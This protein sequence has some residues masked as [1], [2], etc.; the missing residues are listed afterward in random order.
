MSDTNQDAT[1]SLA[2]LRTA[3]FSNSTS[4]RITS[5]GGNQHAL[6]A[7]LSREA[8]DRWLNV[9]RKSMMNQLQ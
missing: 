5:T 9:F 3:L 4:V 6:L 2:C 1:E 8:Y 7:T